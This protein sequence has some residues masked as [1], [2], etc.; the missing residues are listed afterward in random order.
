[1]NHFFLLKKYTIKQNRSNMLHFFLVAVIS[2]I[3]LLLF[4]YYLNSNKIVK[5]I[6][7]KIVHMTWHGFP[8]CNNQFA[9]FKLCSLYFFI[10]ISHSF[11]HNAFYVQIYLSTFV[12]LLLCIIHLVLYND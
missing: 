10:F 7:S 9:Q 11:N 12:Y 1:M 8:I 3:F 4:L 5:V 2:I 6:S